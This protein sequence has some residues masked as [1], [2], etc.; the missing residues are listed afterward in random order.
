M[1]FVGSARFFVSVN[2]SGGLLTG[3]LALF[4][5]MALNLGVLGILLAACVSQIYVFYLFPIFSSKHWLR[6]TELAFGTFKSLI[7]NGMPMLPSLV[8][9]FLLQNGVRWFL[10][11]EFGSNEVGLFTVGTSFGSI[12]GFIFAGVV[13]AWTPWVLSKGNDWETNQDL[14]STRLAQIYVVGM[15]SVGFFF[16]FAKIA[17]FVLADVQFFDAWRVVGITACSAF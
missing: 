12:L 3:I 6:Y 11:N 8:I 7:I 1:Q 15:T 17:V 2:V 13:S 5:L 9:L 10:D 4:F 16:I 14:I